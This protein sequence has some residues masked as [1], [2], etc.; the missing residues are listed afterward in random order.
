MAITTVFWAALAISFLVLA[1]FAQREA[2]AIERLKH[3]SGGPPQPEGSSPRE[4]RLAGDLDV[5]IL[6][7]VVRALRR[8][9]MIEFLGFVLAAA[10]ALFEALAVQ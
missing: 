3:L 5:K 2:R 9:L 10:A 4:V 7:P 1:V 8:I 6:P